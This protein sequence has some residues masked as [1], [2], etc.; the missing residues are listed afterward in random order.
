MLF[1][2]TLCASPMRR[3]IWLEIFNFN[4]NCVIREGSE[5]EVSKVSRLRDISTVALESHFFINIFLKNFR[6]GYYLKKF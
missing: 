6:K 4:F 5:P 3:V 2:I 1:V